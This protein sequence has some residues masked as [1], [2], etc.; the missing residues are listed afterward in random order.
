[1]HAV[2][3]ANAQQLAAKQARSGTGGDNTVEDG[4]QDAVRVF[5]AAEITQYMTAK[6]KAPLGT[7]T[8]VHTDFLFFTLEI[9][10][11]TAVQGR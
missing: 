5:F 11:S 1:M 3:A 6:P 8:Y 9:Y 2:H 7:D 10:L 4:P